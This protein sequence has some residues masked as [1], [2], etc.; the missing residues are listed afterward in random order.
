MQL[1]ESWITHKTCSSLYFGQI[2]QVDITGILQYMIHCKKI[3]RGG[4][5]RKIYSKKTKQKKQKQQSNLHCIHCITTHFQ[6][7]MY[8]NTEMVGGQSAWKSFH[9][10]QIVPAAAEKK[11]IT[12]CGKSESADGN[13][14]SCKALNLILI[15]WLL[16]MTFYWKWNRNLLSNKE[17]TQAA[18]VSFQLTLVTD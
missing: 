1:D 18:T 2:Q 14:S 7:H 11:K 9:L 12:K 5:R 6:F 4:K 10:T 17:W 13:R 8:Q 3:S 16:A 15:V